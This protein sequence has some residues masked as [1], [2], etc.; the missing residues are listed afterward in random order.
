MTACNPLGSGRRIDSDDDDDDDDDEIREWKEKW[1]AQV[2]RT[3]KLQSTLTLIVKD[4][5]LTKQQ[6]EAALAKEAAELRRQRHARRE[7]LQ[8]ETVAQVHLEQEQRKKH[9]MQ[10]R[11]RELAEREENQVLY[12]TR[13]SGQQEEAIRSKSSVITKMQSKI[14]EQTQ[15]TD[16][17]V[18]SARAAAAIPAW[19]LR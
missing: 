1:K 16:A 12:L 2:N 4:Y 3:E 18:R 8:R 11:A 14:E 7:Q 17:F 10:Q 6:Q 15:Q 13:K 9:V 19:I 5:T